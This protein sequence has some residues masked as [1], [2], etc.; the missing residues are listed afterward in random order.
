MK[1]AVQYAVFNKNVNII[2]IV[3]K[4]ESAGDELRNGLM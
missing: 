1:F 2:A 4:T 3:H